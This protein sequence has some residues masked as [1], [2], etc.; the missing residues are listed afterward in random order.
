MRCRQRESAEK[1]D[2]GLEG[3]ELLPRE[4]GDMKIRAYR[5]IA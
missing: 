3:Y 5:R 1:L 2:E 4:G